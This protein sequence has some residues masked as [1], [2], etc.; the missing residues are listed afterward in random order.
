MSN[1]RRGDEKSDYSKRLKQS[2]EELR[3]LDKRMQ[4]LERKKRKG[5]LTNEE[6][7]E[8]EYLS[9]T[10]VDELTMKAL[11]LFMSDS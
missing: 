3:A 2:V 8:L 10:E 4:V 11:D 9:T 5:E 1:E 7:E 6:K